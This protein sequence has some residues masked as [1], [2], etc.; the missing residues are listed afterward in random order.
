MPNI[1]V[2][3]LIVIFSSIRGATLQRM[4]HGKI[5][6]NFA[7]SRCY[8]HAVLWCFKMQSIDTKSIFMHKERKV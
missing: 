1:F 3:K 2:G 6:E 4:R 7:R 5:C 8:M